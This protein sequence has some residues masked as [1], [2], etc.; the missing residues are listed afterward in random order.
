V[1]WI[2]K[3][4]VDVPSLFRNDVRL[5]EKV[6]DSTGSAGTAGQQLL[7][8]AT[9][10]VW[11]DQTYTYTQNG[12][13]HTWVI[14]HDLNKFPSATVIDSGGSVVVGC[15]VYNSTNQLTITFHAGGAPSAFSGKAY[16]N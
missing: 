7:S 16:L 14:E 9:A 10:T 2:G 3:N 5:D 11:T 4:I 1:K 6:V 8:T 15:I 13:S 12:S